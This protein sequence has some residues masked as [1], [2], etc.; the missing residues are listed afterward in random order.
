MLS[1]PNATSTKYC[2]DQLLSLCNAQIDKLD[3]LNNLGIN[4]TL[5]MLNSVSYAL[6]VQLEMTNNSLITNVCV[7]NNKNQLLRCKLIKYKNGA[8][9][10]LQTSASAPASAL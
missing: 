4:V 9:C 3:T 8:I 7:N 6:T 5:C 2:H 1:K 10:C